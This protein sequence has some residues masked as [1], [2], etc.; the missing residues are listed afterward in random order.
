MTTARFPI[1]SF[2]EQSQTDCILLSPSLK[3]KSKN[4][5]TAFTNKEIEDGIWVVSFLGFDLGYFDRNNS[6]VEPVG[7]PFNKK[8]LPM[9]PV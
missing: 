7:D 5:T 3:R 6:R 8:V 2:L 4:A 1:A 9:S